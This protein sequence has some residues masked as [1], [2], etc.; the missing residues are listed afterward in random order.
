MKKQLAIFIALLVILNIFQVMPIYAA[1]ELS[2]KQKEA[3]AVI[4]GLGLADK[5]DISED[6]GNDTITRAEFASIM[7]SLTGDTY[8]AE[9][10][11]YFDVPADSEF[12]DEI[13]TQRDKGIMV[14]Y[15]DIDFGAKK[16]I[17]LA[18]ATVTLLRVLGYDPAVKMGLADIKSL[19]GNVKL[20]NGVNTANVDAITKCDAAV[21]VHN[22][23]TAGTLV[24][25]FTAEDSYAIDYDK[26]ILYTNLGI[27]KIEG[28]VSQVYYSALTADTL[29]KTG[30]NNAVVSDMVLNYKEYPETKD[31]LGYNVDCYYH[32]GDAED[33]IVFMLPK[34]NT[35]YKVD[36]ED[37]EGYANGV[38]RYTERDVNYYVTEKVKSLKLSDTVDVV[39][40]GV[41]CPDYTVDDL[42][43]TNTSGFSEFID[44]NN[45]GR[46]EV[47]IITECRDYVVDYVNDGRKTIYTKWQEN[48]EL[49]GVENL[50]VYDVS[51]KTIEFEAIMSSDIATIQ[52]S[53][54]GKNAV[55]IRTNNSIDT[56]VKKIDY[57]NHKI[58]LDNGKTY[59]VDNSLWARIDDIRTDSY[60]MFFFDYRGRLAGL[61]FENYGYNETY[62]YLSRVKCDEDSEVVTAKLFLMSGEMKTYE[63]KK[64][65]ICD[66][67]QIR[68]TEFY[69]RMMLTDVNGT[70]Y[71][72]RQ[73]VRFKLNED[74][75]LVY[76]DTASKGVNEGDDT[77]VVRGY[78]NATNYDAYAPGGLVGYAECAQLLSCIAVPVPGNNEPK[79]NVNYYADSDYYKCSVYGK[80]VENF[81][82]F[83]LSK[84]GVMSMMV[85]YYTKSETTE[86]YGGD[87]NFEREYK[88]SNPVI[89]DNIT[90]ELYDD[91]AAFLVKY[92]ERN[93]KKE[94][95]VTDE[96]ILMKPEY[97]EDGIATGRYRRISKGD[98]VRIHKKN[99]NIIDSIHLDYDSERT[100]N[101]VF[102]STGLGIDTIECG[103]AYF[104][105]ETG[106]KML[107]DVRSLGRYSPSGMILDN[108]ITRQYNDSICFTLYDRNNKTVSGGNWSD[109]V[110]YKQD[111]SNPSIVVAYCGDCSYTQ[112]FIYR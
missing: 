40:N 22:A 45:D 95:Y 41:A 70:K 75:K 38:F 69:D 5:A 16:D 107:T 26:N 66:G 23:L 29:F 83:G 49:S 53:K 39:Y 81:D 101:R 36:S 35:V 64:K 33:S 46:Y 55:I 104:G 85:K 94:A 58:T 88:Q 54:D 65:M 100:D 48:V 97:S 61:M 25:K 3:I 78:R 80:Y 1:P 15:S 106:I 19:A 47:V 9:N 59:R 112:I 44:N 99:D 79:S 86:N 82:A 102:I 89:I 56:A 109:V 67:D 108:W 6:T 18:E 90:Q 73:V 11:T 105:S 7:A 4:N 24:R 111:S 37:F 57:A 31:Y 10:L 50:Y 74:G 42:L 76:I 2:V 21:M 17:N 12:A 96:K 8:T 77:L 43:L 20:Y 93:V 13:Y 84:A 110:G 72:D 30:E 34:N 27:K 68:A 52:M 87:I 14:G 62:A 98:V 92:F 103:V 63:L 91:D 60:G 71:T 28:V 51:G 32:E